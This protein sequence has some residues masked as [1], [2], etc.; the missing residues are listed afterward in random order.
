MFINY[1]SVSDPGSVVFSL[2]GENTIPA[3]SQNEQKLRRE[4]LFEFTFCDP[5]GG[6]FPYRNSIPFRC[7]RIKDSHTQRKAF[8]F[9]DASK[10]V[11]LL[12]VTT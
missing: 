1:I 8:R 2:V 11:C 5:T 9:P 7:I 4:L 6:I 3:P 12:R 10:V